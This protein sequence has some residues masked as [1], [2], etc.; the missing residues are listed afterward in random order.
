MKDLL[1]GV[2]DVLNKGVSEVERQTQLGR[3]RFELRSLTSDRSHLFERM[4]REAFFL[5]KEGTI[6]SPPQLEKPL[7]LIHKLEAEMERLEQQ[8]QGLEQGQ[9][10]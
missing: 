10:S 5:M 8:I 1:E 6:S 7:N 2:R 3:L 9:G 4:G